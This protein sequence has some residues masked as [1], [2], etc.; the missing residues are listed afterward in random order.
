MTSSLQKLSRTYQGLLHLYG[1][2]S[3]A[4]GDVFCV[5]D[6]LRVKEDDHFFGPSCMDF[7]FSVAW[8]ALLHSLH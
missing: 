8:L 4:L 6:T 7:G 2:D 1:V 5:D 3:F